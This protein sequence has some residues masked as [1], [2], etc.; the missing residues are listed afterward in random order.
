MVLEARI[1]RAVAYTLVPV[2]SGCSLATNS[3]HGPFAVTLA[4]GD[5]VEAAVEHCSGAG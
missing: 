2:P 5:R 1:L 3:P 4:E